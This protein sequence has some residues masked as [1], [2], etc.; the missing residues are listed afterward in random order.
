[1]GGS[2]NEVRNAVSHA[3]IDAIEGVGAHINE[4]FSAMLRFL[5]VANGGDAPLLSCH[6]LHLLNIRKAGCIGGDTANGMPLH[7]PFRVNRQVAE[8]DFAQYFASTPVVVLEFSRG[9]TGVFLWEYWL[10]DWLRFV[11][12][13]ASR[14]F[15]ECQSYRSKQQNCASKN[16]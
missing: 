5:P 4:F 9:G 10:F 12:F 11:S 2:R 14:H 8:F 6:Y 16:A 13:L 1:M 3:F 15:G 7:T